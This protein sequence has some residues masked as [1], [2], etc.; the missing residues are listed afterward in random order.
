MPAKSGI[1]KS[2][3]AQTS[4]AKTG[5][6]R[7]VPKKAAPTPGRSGGA[8]ARTVDS[9]VARG[10]NLVIVRA[11]INRV[12]ESR[13]LASGDEV[14]AFDM[15]IRAEGGPAES[16]PVIWTNPPAAAHNLAEGDDVVVL[17]AIRRRFFRSGGT[18]AS[19]TEL[20]A[21]RIVPAGARAK[22]RSVLESALG[23]LV[24]DAP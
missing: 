10:T 13:V 18:T 11:V 8:I 22:V 2:R 5:S 15:T 20:N 17:G 3:P 21:S 23:S 1:S 19:R 7:T 24:G 4:P 12:P 16:V 9:S 14:F 6:F